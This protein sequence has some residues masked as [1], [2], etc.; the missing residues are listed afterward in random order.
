MSYLHYLCLFTYS[1]V[2][3]IL[4]F[5]FVLIVY[6][7]CMLCCQFI[8]LF[9]IFR[10]GITESA[11]RRYLTR[12]PMT[13]K[14]LVQKFNA[15]KLNLSKEQMTSTIAQLLKK[16]HP[17]KKYINKTM[18]LSLKADWVFVLWCLG[19]CWGTNHQCNIVFSPKSD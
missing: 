6:I 9:Y 5:A 12:K 10:D 13:P 11:I 2:Q 3:H 19:S 17:E 18:Y 7:L 4:C 8:Y 1:G 15:K 14:E 16:I